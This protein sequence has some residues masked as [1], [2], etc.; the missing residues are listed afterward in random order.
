MFANFTTIPR[1][2]ENT[3]ASNYSGL[4][5]TTQFVNQKFVE[6]VWR[7]QSIDVFF[8]NP[9]SCFHVNQSGFQVECVENE[10]KTQIT[11]SLTVT[12]PLDMSYNPVAV[13]LI[14]RIQ[15]NP[16]AQTIASLNLIIRGKLLG[17]TLGYSKTS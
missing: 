16:I 14:C 2:P 3:L 10:D 4:R 17:Y 9:L 11:T 5:L 6:C 13:A 8:L 1:L 15:E 12:Y 7:F